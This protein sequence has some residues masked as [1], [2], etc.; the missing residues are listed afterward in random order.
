MF[1]LI[2]I[3]VTLGLRRIMQPLG[4]LANESEKEGSGKEGTGVDG[5]MH[6][7]TIAD[8]RRPIPAKT[9]ASDKVRV[10]ARVSV[11]TLGG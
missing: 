1:G 4:A 3:T 7:G 2:R 8:T 11:L 9:H 5:S 6:S 10:M